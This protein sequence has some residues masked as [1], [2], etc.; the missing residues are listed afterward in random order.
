MKVDSK[1][2][3][4]GQK[5]KT[6]NFGKSIS[7]KF[8]KYTSRDSN[9][10][11]ASMDEGNGNQQNFSGTG[12]TLGSSSE[13]NTGQFDSQHTLSILKEQRESQADAN[14]APVTDE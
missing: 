12:T 5:I 7:K 9:Q 10:R 13:E 3:Q 2:Q 14:I 4:F 11:R 8:G 6:S 1:L